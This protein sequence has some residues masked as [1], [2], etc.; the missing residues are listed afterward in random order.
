MAC[1][2]RT[3][4][5]V[6]LFFTGLAFGSLA[7]SPV[8]NDWLDRLDDIGLPLIG[9][10][11]LVCFLVSS[12]R[13]QRS[14]IPLGLAGLALVIQIIVIP[15][16]RDDAAAFGD[17]IGGLIMYLPFFVFAHVYNLRSG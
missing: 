14:V 15:L 13:Q 12:H 6:V 11:G 9:V 5:I 3:A 17:N 1:H 2:T 7:F 10:M 16:E 4:S 8:E